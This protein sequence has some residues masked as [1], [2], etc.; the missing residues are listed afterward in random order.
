M[1]KKINEV[2]YLTTDENAQYFE[3]GYSCDNALFL[4]LGSDKFF[5]TD[6]RYSLEAEKIAQNTNIIESSDLIAS[7]CEILNRTSIKTLIYDPSQLTISVFEKIKAL[8]KTHVKLLPESRFHQLLRI[9]KTDDEIIKIK[10]SQKLNKDAYKGFAKFINGSKKSFTERELYY[11]AQQFLTYLGKYD[12]SFD[13]IL[14]VN[15]NAA[16]PH[17]LPS[18]KDK[19]EYEDLLL[20]DAGIKYQRYCSDRTRTAFYDKEGIH[21][22]KKQKFKNKQIQ[23]IY[24]IVLKAQEKTINLLRSGMSGAEIDSIARKVIEKSGYG[25][26]FV[27]STGHGIGLDIH[28]LPFISKSSEIIIE[29]N[30]V[31]SIEPGIYIPD[32]YGVRI[33]DLIVVKN[34]KAEII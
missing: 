32:H 22:R 20:F 17:A 13:P 23:K 11:Q 16:K 24:D 26:Y 2:N 30:M 31:F 12:L 28:E 21:F 29:D 14:G 1:K 6:S 7:A 5:I 19:L 15:A 10:K 4:K 34:G 3:C 8:L 33:E 27:H 18:K 25:K 9:I